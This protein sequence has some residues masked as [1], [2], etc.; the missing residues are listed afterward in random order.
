MAWP[1]NAW[2]LT[3]RSKAASD[4]FS[5]SYDGGGPWDASRCAAEM[6]QHTRALRDV[7]RYYFR[8]ATDIGS[9]R[10]SPLH[11]RHG[12]QMSIHAVGRA[13]DVMVPHV[14][15]NEGE[16]LANWLVENAALLGLQLVIWRH[17][18]WQGS[19]PRARRFDQY[20]GSN[21]HVDHV[22]VEVTET[23]GPLLAWLMGGADPAMAPGTLASPQSVT[24]R[25]DAES[26]D[27]GGGGGF[28][29]LLVLVLASGW[30]GRR[31]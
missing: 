11:T 8:W 16:S 28:V 31:R 12:D 5:G 1:N 25:D 27:A 10:C 7:V 30:R 15:G 13:L 17:S 2:T 24:V 3:P 6:A 29:L 18:V 14:G 22:H 26:G 4:A 20:T 9:V 21:P 19:Q 23:P